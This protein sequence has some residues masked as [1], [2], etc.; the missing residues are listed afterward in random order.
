[1]RPDMTVEHNDVGAHH[2]VGGGGRSWFL[3][4]QH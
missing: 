3:W 2:G 4:F 1:M